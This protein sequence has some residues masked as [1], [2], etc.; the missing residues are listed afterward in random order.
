MPGESRS[1][2]RARKE[3]NY[4]LTLS[5]DLTLTHSVPEIEGLF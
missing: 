5:R 4:D 2:I 1:W 3:L